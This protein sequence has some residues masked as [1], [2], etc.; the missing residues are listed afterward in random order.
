MQINTEFEPESL[1]GRDHLADLG[2]DEKKIFTYILKTSVMRVCTGFIWLMIKSS[3]AIM[4]TGLTVY[5][6][7]N[8][9]SN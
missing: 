1:R 3:G 5:T 4:T 7:G 2:I 8:S 9:L 6:V